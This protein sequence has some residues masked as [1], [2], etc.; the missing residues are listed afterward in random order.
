M[1]IY[2]YIYTY[3][4]LFIGGLWINITNVE[5]KNRLFCGRYMQI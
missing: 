2:T 3:I 1:V 5:K 4:K